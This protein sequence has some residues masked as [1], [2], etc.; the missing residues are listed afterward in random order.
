MKEQYVW[1][2]WALA[3]LVPWAVL[4]AGFPSQRRT[5]LW[6]SFFTA[7]FG[8][9]EPLLVPEYRTPPTLFDLAMKT[10]FDS[11]SLIF[12]FCFGGVGA[13]FYNVLSGA[14]LATVTDSER[15]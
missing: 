13:V 12:C 10:D 7:P 11:K 2:A 3:F 1:F 15:C 8:L 14:R 9:T 5:M 6:A 4:Y